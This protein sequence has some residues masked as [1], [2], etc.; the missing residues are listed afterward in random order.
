MF[1]TF[2]MAFA[3]MLILEGLLPFIS[4]RIWRETFK[5]LTEIHDGQIRFI[6][7]T[8]MLIGLALFLI[9]S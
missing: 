1:E 4:P 9:L 7:L 3:L 5:K 8:S 2:L 6:G